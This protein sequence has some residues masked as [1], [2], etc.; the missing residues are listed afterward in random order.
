MKQT[1]FL[2][3]ILLVP[4][5]AGMN[6]DTVISISK[7]D[8][9]TETITFQTNES[10]DSFAF[11]TLS[12]PLSIIYDGE[13]AIKELENSYLITFQKSNNELTFSLLFDD[14]VECNK[15]NRIFRTGFTSS[16]QTSVT[17][18]LPTGFV[19]S[20]KAPQA[21]PM[22]DKIETDGQRI[23]LKWHFDDDSV[24][25]VFYK[26]P[27][28]HT[29]FFIISILT[30]ILITFCLFLYFRTHFKRTIKETLSEDEQ[31]IVKELCN[32]V[33]IQK[34]IARN[35]GFS[36]SKMSKV[37]RKLEEKGLV[38]KTPYFKTNKI[39]LKKIR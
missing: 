37:L 31:L 5:A 7:N 32:R 2:L 28:S 25:A 12:E 11:E 20:D 36:K 18:I 13:Y 8:I 17:V 23:K 22:P 16:D 1:L 29:N 24:I 4:F 21:T 9:V 14:L 19:L 10:Y 33:K 27:K 6:I 3:F 39:K 34:T 35:L 38:E 15:Q 30:I 26:G